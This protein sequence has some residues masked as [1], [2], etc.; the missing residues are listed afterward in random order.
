MKKYSLI[1]SA[2]I[3]IFAIWFFAKKYQLDQKATV[4]SMP[5]ISQLQ[6]LSLIRNDQTQISEQDFKNHIWVLNFFFTRCQGPCP[7]MSQKMARLQKEFSQFESIRLASISVDPE[8]DTPQVLTEY[9]QKYQANN[10]KWWFLTGNKQDIISL[11]VNIFKLP[12]T[13]QPDMHSVRFI[14]IDQNGGIR[15]YYDSNVSED[16]DK[17]IEHAKALASYPSS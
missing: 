5:V 4:N 1:L 15:G 8:H 16:L 14:L 3:L 13:E 6:A 10:Q 17:L 11:G 9:G 7:M 12:A 2:A